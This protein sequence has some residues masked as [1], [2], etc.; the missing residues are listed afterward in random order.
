MWLLQV[1]RAGRS[2]FPTAS[3]ESQR[4]SESQSGWRRK[5]RLGRGVSLGLTPL[6][7]NR[8]NRGRVCRSWDGP[9]QQCGI[10]GRLP[11]E[12]WLCSASCLE[13]PRAENAPMDVTVAF[14]A[15]WDASQGVRR[16]QLQALLGRNLPQVES[17]PALSRLGSVPKGSPNGRKTESTNFKFLLKHL[18]Y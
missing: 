3:G 6:E 11:R 18:Q 9:A 8:E 7:G 17:A 1:W 15:N 10:P 5:A 14:D 16:D 12:F 4:A 2:P 13:R